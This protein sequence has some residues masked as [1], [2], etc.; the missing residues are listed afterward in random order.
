MNEV[1]YSAPKIAQAVDACQT[2]TKNVKS[3]MD[4]AMSAVQE[5]ASV[6]DGEYSAAF[7]KAQ[8]KWG[9]ALD[10]IETATGNFAIRLA[11]ASDKMSRTDR[12]WADQLGSI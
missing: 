4:D 5:R 9:T 3:I 8:T 6:S 11:D 12:N 1:L 2:F 7:T 10:N